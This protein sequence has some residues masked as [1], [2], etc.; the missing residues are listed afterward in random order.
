MKFTPEQIRWLINLIIEF[1]GEDV[2]SRIDPELV[3]DYIEKNPMPEENEP[4]NPYILHGDAFKEAIERRKSNGRIDITL[5][6]NL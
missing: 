3:R 2:D 1:G 4:E 5:K 6:E